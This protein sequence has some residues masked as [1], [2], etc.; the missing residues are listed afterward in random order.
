MERNH[1]ILNAKSILLILLLVTTGCATTSKLSGDFNPDDPYEKSNRKVFEFN[2]KIDKLFL[3]PVTDFYDKA[4]PEF[5]QTSITNFFANL[6]DIRISINNLLQGNV[7]ESMS[8]ITRFFINS[9]F[10]L[11][12]FFDVASEMGLEKHSEDFG[13]T[14]GKWGAKSG[15]Y[16]MLPFLGPSTTRDAFTFVGD[17]ALAPA[18]SLDDNAARVGL[19]SL[20]LINTYSAFTGIADIESKDQYAFL[21]DAYLERRKYEINDGLSEEELSQDE[22]FEDF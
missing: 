1:F 10:G 19:I 8:D 6:D 12:G 17:T 4:T 16:L 11:G 7:V 9:I 14:L 20:D 18:L 3:R 21:R 5:A 2:N 22:D 13:Q 15:P